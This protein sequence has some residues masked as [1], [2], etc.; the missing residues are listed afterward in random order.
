M[1]MSHKGAIIFTHLACWSGQL[2]LVC[3]LDHRQYHNRL[4]TD[5]TINT[6]PFVKVSSWNF[7]S[8]C[9][10]IQPA[11]SSW[12]SG[13]L[14]SSPFLSRSFSKCNPL[15]WCTHSTQIYAHSHKHTHTHTHTLTGTKHTHEHKAH[16]RAQTHE[17]QI[18]TYC[19]YTH[20]QT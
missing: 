15:Q 12:S 19:K 16:A 14:A 20:I 1:T 17:L 5:G 6:R 9:T 3:T 4:I 18:H 11:W 10:H 13:T 7:G 8:S 2:Q